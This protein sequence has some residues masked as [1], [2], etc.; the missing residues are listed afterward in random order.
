M[1]R[2]ADDG[3]KRALEGMVSNAEEI[4]Q[5]QSRVDELDKWVD[6][7]CRLMEQVAELQAR[8]EKMTQSSKDKM[9]AMERKTTEAIAQMEQRL[10]S[11]VNTLGGAVAPRVQTLERE[12]PAL[13]SMM[14]RQIQGLELEMQ[15]RKE[16]Q[17][18]LMKAVMSD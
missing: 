11:R 4:R 9:N 15:S 18:K 17:Q 3:Q 16:A 7:C 14:M 12:V 10:E 1:K 5:L 6:E 2:R 13:Q 8:F